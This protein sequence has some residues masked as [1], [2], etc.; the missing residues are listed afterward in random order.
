MFVGKSSIDSRLFQE[1]LRHR[2]H[3]VQLELKNCDG[4]STLSALPDSLM[5]L[6]Y[7][8]LS[9]PHSISPKEFQIL[10]SFPTA[11]RYLDLSMC[12]IDDIQILQRFS[13]IRSSNNCLLLKDYCLAILSVVKNYVLFGRFRIHQSFTFLFAC[14][15]FLWYIAAPSKSSCCRSK[16]FFVFWFGV[17]VFPDYDMNI[18]LSISFKVRVVISIIL[19]YLI[20]WHYPY[21]GR[22]L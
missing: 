5:R 13:G 15:C 19:L 22:W 18:H 9:N 3:L 21:W 11:L 8:Q 7:F 6:S 12:S 4:I 2:V 17:F 10:L 16:Y 1:M 20:F 14:Y